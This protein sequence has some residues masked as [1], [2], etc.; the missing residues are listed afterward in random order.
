MSGSFTQFPVPNINIPALP[1]VSPV[2]DASLFVMERAGTGRVTAA[3]LRSYVRMSDIINARD[4]GATGDGVSDD[5]A[6]LQAA[7]DAAAAVGGTVVIPSGTYLVTDTLAIG[8]GAEGV[9]SSKAGIMV[10]GTVPPPFP[11][12][13]GSPWTPILA[14]VPC[15]RIVWSGGSGAGNAVIDIRGP[16]CSWGL[17]NLYIDGNNAADHGLRIYSAMRG[18]CA[19][20]TIANCLANQILS[21]TRATAPSGALSNSMHNNF[22]NIIVSVSWNRDFGCGVRLEGQGSNGNTC[23]CNF[24]DLFVSMASNTSLTAVFGL[25][26]QACDSNEFFNV[27]FVN[28][29]PGNG[30]AVMYDYGGITPDWP[31]GNTIWGGDWGGLNGPVQHAGAPGANAAAN[32][33]A[34]INQANHGAYPDPTVPNLSVVGGVV[35]Q[36]RQDNAAAAIGWTTLYVPSNTERHGL[37]QC[38]Y[39]LETSDS[40]A[41]GGGTITL[42]FSWLDGV[43][44]PVH[45]SAPVSAGPTGG[46][47]AHGSFSFYAAGTITWSTTLAGIASGTPLY[48]TQIA[49]SRVA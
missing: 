17:Q 33:I 24:Y 15:T 48:T 9:I 18:D 19:N 2:T 47:N 31:A 29:N 23:Y 27:H 1:D 45:S 32:T 35:A 8:N 21:T 10:S 12:I 41:T 11:D 38:H 40:S 44:S 25:Y 5:T 26:L 42:N 3:A 39:Y 6:A 34:A 16:L 22:R 14:A 4:Y 13:L 28:G 46:N 36:A 49:L 30:C 43:G 20:L 7:F 37:Y